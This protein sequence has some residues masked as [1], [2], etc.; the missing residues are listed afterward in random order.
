V[1]TAVKLMYLGAAISTASLIASLADIGAIKPALRSEFPH[2]T[3]S[4]INQAFKG[5]LILALVSAGINGWFLLPD[6][7]YAGRTLIS[8]A[9]FSWS[10]TSGFDTVGVVLNPLRTVPST[11][12]VPAL[13]AQAPVW[14]M[15]WGVIAGI[16]LWRDAAMA[17]LRRAWAIAVLGVAIVLW[18]MLFQWPWEHMPSALQEIQFPYRLGSYVTLLSVGLVIVAVLAAQRLASRSEG[19]V[20]TLWSLRTLLVEAVV[21]SLL[22]CLWQLWVPNTHQSS[23]YSVRGDALKSLTDTPKTW[24][25]GPDYA[26]NWLP[27]VQVPA[28][29]SL[30]IDA[31]A[32]DA[33][34][35][36]VSVDVAAPPG[37]QPIA[38][39][40]LAGPYLVEVSGVRVVGRTG[41]GLVVTRLNAGAGKVHLVVST[42][43]SR[44]VT[45]G[46]AISAAS[47]LA[48]LV[49]LG[50]LMIG[51][52]RDRRSRAGAGWAPR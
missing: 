33:A 11:S 20:G 46:R 28:N 37:P 49:L 3:A 23:Y 36:H 1:L 8:G 29:R 2:Y 7:I 45:L 43:A 34:G 4:Q 13:Y 14:F 32:V 22:L 9:G 48:V 19:S 5:F 10:G 40:I 26:D 18:L 15:A 35:N 6:I 44:A 30:N 17:R 12:S 42:R 24:G 52:W 27:S 21:V 47:L 41:S 50:W 51:G 38:T 16:W 39:N 31:R 25:S